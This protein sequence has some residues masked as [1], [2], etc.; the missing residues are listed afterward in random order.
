MF[1]RN[2][3]TDTIVLMRL[4]FRG[5]RLPVG[6]MNLTPTELHASATGEVLDSAKEGREESFEVASIISYG[7]ILRLTQTYI[8]HR[9]IG[10]I[11]VRTLQRTARQPCA[12]SGG[13][14]RLSL[15]F[16]VDGTRY[17]K[18]EELVIC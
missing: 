13:P 14:H 2:R 10:S 5:D 3:L 12:L 16:I 18:S 4:T 11:V 1:L 17:R 6:Q 15:F 7:K 8:M 9:S